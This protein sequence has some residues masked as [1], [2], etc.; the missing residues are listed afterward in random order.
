MSTHIRSVPLHFFLVHFAEPAFGT[1]HSTGMLDFHDLVEKRLRVNVGFTLDGARVM[2]LID[3]N[4][5]VVLSADQARCSLTHSAD[6]RFDAAVKGVQLYVENTL[7]TSK[8]PVLRPIDAT[9]GIVRNPL[10][11]DPSEQ[12]QPHF[13]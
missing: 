2:L 6:D 5:M 13:M 11:Q 10:T 4:E 3:K 1:S 8:S 12:Q 7:T 9:L